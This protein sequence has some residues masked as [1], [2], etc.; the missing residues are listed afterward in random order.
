MR[1][2]S[3]VA[4]LIF[5]CLPIAAGCSG[6]PARVVAPR[7]DPVA[8]T[9][10][11]FQ[12]ADEDRDGGLRGGEQRTVP[13]IAAAAERLDGDADGAVSR[14]ELSRWLTAVR[15][16]RI[17]ITRFEMTISQRRRP[18]A[19][20]QVR[21]V[22]EPFMGG[23]VQAAEGTTDADGAVLVTIPGAKYPGVNCGLYR[24]AI[25]GTGNDGKPL[26]ERFASASTFGVAVGAGLPETA[27]VLDLPAE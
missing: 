21:L 3:H 2:T 26:G 18:L 19:N 16:A 8:V 23:E 14:E 10:A 13:A 15:D 20:A 1:R 6:R 22:P 9:E 27:V 4:S 7:I 11:V 12:A 5:A 25:T 24:V 17:A